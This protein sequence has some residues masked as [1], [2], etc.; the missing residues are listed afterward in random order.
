MDPSSAAVLFDIDG[1]L[2]DSTYHHA[3]AWQRAFARHDL[4]VPMWRIHRAIGMGGDRLV[5]HVTGE[6]T[7][8]RLG[9]ALREAWRTEYL[10]LRHEVE[11]LP[12]AREVIVRL[13]AEGYRVALASSGDPEFSQE[14]VERLRVAD[15][16]EALTTAEDVEES[17]PEPD[18]LGTTLD[19]LP[20]VGRAVLVG[21]TVYDVQSSA[22][23]GLSCIGL[24]SGGI[25][26]AELLDAGAALVVDTVQD[27]IEL[28][29][30]DYLSP[31]HR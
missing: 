15:E 29:W 31:V 17:K 7:E 14:A 20:G 27:L 9:D 25:S 24:R 8:E 18:L 5:A 6:A 11:P 2:L 28:R 19:R 13:R 30:D 1:T 4:V 12:G 26:T 21:D 22:R 10:P 23:A 3:L 16:I